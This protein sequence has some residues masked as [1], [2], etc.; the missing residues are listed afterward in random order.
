MAM[1]ISIIKRF[2]LERFHDQSAQMA[3][4]F[5]L[6]IFPFLI[7]AFSLVSFLPIQ[8]VDVLDAINRL[9]QKAGTG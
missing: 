2:F 7:F 1:I 3:Y 8:S 4:Y 5:L 9:H 6:S